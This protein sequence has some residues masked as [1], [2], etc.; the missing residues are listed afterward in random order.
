MAEIKL[1]SIHKAF[2]D[3]TVII[4]VDIDIN[5]G[6]FVGFVGPSGSG[7]STFA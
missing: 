3:L 7:K 1:E 2:D 6:E 5:D 4:G